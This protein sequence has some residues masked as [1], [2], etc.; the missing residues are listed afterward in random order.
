[1]RKIPMHPA[2]WY[3]LELAVLI[4]WVAVWTTLT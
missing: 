1:V 2:G 3:V 4:A